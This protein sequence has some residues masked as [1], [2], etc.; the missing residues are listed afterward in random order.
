M[1][2]YASPVWFFGYEIT[3]D[4]VSVIIALAVSISAFRIYHLTGQRQLKLFGIGFILLA[5]S[6]L[7]QFIIA[8]LILLEYT[9]VI[10]G[11]LISRG[12]LGFS[13]LGIILYLAFFIAGLI[14]LAYMTFNIKSSKAYLMMLFLSGI[15]V[16]LSY[17]HVV[18]FFLISTAALMFLI[19]HYTVHF[20]K[21]RHLTNFLVLVA[22][23][24]FLAGSINYVLVPFQL[25]CFV[26]GN[27]F[28]L[29]GMVL[30]LV[31]LILVIKK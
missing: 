28:E 22:F 11:Q 13:M 9:E 2:C 21:T 4:V 16:F 27:L 31:N 24:F 20:L 12:L 14:T 5:V 8:E 15:A 23:I 3:I 10:E 25:D 1:T 29:F 19:Y 26:V 17:D 30:I 18:V 7:L 6:Y